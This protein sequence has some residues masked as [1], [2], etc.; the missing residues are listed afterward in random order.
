MVDPRLWADGPAKKDVFQVLNVAMFCL[1]QNPSLR[2][3]MSEIVA[4]LISKA[5]MVGTPVKPTFLGRRH[6]SNEDVSWEAISE[7]FP[8]PLPSDSP[9]FPQ[10]N[11][12]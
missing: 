5:Q 2:P 1:Q 4:M 9:S 10:P 12:S 6:Q 7:L 8:S 11:G 3:P